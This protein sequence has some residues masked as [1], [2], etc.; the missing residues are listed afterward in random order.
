MELIRGIADSAARQAIVAGIL[1][2]AR[3]LD[4]TIIAEGIETEAELAT[5]R[6][7]GISLFQ[8]F[9]FARPAIETLPS[10]SFNA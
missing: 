3:T 2:M 10:V 1:L 9:L 5:L 6:S 7:A 4:I 8:G